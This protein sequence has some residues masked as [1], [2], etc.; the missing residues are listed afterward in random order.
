MTDPRH[1]FHPVQRSTLSASESRLTGEYHRN[2]ERLKSGYGE[3]EE[4]FVSGGDHLSKSLVGRI[5][6][7]RFLAMKLL[8]SKTSS[9]TDVLKRFLWRIASDSLMLG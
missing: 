6:H 3:S 2:P 7:A 5:F 4:W 9:C 1:L 8:S